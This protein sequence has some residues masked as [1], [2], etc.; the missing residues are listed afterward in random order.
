LRTAINLV[1]TPRVSQHFDS[2]LALRR[3]QRIG[4]RQPIA[5]SRGLHGVNLHLCH[6]YHEDSW[7]QDQR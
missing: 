5:K 7:R 4:L 1:P 6:T 2:P 3:C